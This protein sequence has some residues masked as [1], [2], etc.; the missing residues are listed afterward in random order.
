MQK[1]LTGTVKRVFSGNH[2]QLQ[3]KIGKSG[4]PL[5]R[6][7]YL[8]GISANNLSTFAEPIEELYPAFESREFLRNLLIGRF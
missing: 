7:L 2:I 6:D 3:G 5:E 1:T 4:I 8:I